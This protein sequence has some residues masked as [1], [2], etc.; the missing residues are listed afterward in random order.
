MVRRNNNDGIVLRCSFRHKRQEDVRRLIASSPSVCI[1]DECIEACRT[2][3][4]EEENVFA[5]NASSTNDLKPADI[6]SFLD[7]Y[8]IAQEQA[9]KKLSV[10]VYNHYKRI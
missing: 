10:A 4:I 2:L 5:R 3:L 7:G 1:C 6:K 8:V 9:K